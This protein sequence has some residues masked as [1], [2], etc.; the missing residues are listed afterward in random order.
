MKIK[1]FNESNSNELDIQYFKFIFSE[2]LDEGAEGFNRDGDTDEIEDYYEIFIKEPVLKNTSMFDYYEENIKEV[3]NFSNN[4]KSCINRVK[5]EYPDIKIEFDFEDVQIDR[6]GMIERNI[7]LI[8]TL[9][10]HI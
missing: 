6:Q 2:F 5:E 8:F 1:K 7:H 3:Y 10:N 9:S 4:L